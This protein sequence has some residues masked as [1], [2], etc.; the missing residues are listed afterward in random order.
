MHGPAIDEL[1]KNIGQIS[2]RVDFVQ[3]C[4]LN[5]RCETCPVDRALVVTG[6]LQGLSTLSESLGD[7]HLDVRAPAEGKTA[8]EAG[9]K[10]GAGVG[11]A[12]G[13]ICAGRGSN[14]AAEG[15][16]ASEPDTAAHSV[17]T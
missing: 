17:V 5:E 6:G 13:A 14:A 3:L 9:M 8:C 15:G 7:A 16:A 2:L 4:G 12:T 1:G 10:A 11:T